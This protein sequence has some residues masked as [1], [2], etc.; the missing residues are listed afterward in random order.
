MDNGDWVF[1]VA[2]F[3]AKK[4]LVRI[5]SNVYFMFV[6]MSKKT[7]IISSHITTALFVMATIVL[8]VFTAIHNIWIFVFFWIHWY[9]SVF[10]Q[11]FFLHRYAAHAMF[12]T[13][14]FWERVFHFFT[15]VAQ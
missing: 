15:W 10:M 6:A 2:F 4:L 12:T 8:L 11:S 1:S 14:K 3:V 13:S 9:V 7:L 5:V